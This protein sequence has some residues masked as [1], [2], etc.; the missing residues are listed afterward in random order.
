MA[1]GEI[2]QNKDLRG[3]EKGENGIKRGKRPSSFRL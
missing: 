1:A 3:K 2:K